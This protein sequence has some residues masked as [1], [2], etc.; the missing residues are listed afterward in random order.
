MTTGE[1]ISDTSYAANSLDLVAVLSD[2]MSEH[3]LTQLPIVDA[4]NYVGLVSEDDL[5]GIDNSVVLNEAGILLRPIFIH[6]DQ[7]VY[8]ALRLFNMHHLEILPVLDNQNRY[9]GVIKIADLMNALAVVTAVEVAGGIIVL[10]IGN[11][12][13]ALSQIA[14]I[15][16]SANAQVLSSYVRA[17]PDSTKLE[18]TLKVNR[19]E[20]SDIVAAFVRYDYVIINT[21][22]DI[23]EYDSTR[24]RYDH[25]MH[26]LNI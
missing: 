16:E 15:V 26:F 18:V 5:I 6:D 10:E 22:N 13:N 12:D 21:Y 11:R 25:L 2:R 19:L 9:L 1:I 23:R 7:H 17:F 14:K 20:I 8:D 3:K 24:E 4:L